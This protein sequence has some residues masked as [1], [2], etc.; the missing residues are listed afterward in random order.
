MAKRSRATFSTNQKLK[1]IRLRYTCFPALN[2]GYMSLPRRSC[3]IGQ[4]NYLGNHFKTALKHG[5]CL[6]TVTTWVVLLKF[7]VPSILREMTLLAPDFRNIFQLFRSA[8]QSQAGGPD[9]TLYKAELLSFLS[10][11]FLNFQKQLLH[12]AI[13]PSL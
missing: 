7:Q 11:F 13:C 5:N 10:H 1:P 2:A 4:G 6:T 12:S 3:V 9:I 8:I